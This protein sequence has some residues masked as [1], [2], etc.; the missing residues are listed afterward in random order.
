MTATLLLLLLAQ[1]KPK[2]RTFDES[3]ALAKKEALA[4]NREAALFKVAYAS[5][6]LFDV[7]PQ[8]DRVSDL[9]FQF[10][11]R[12]GCPPGEMKLKSWTLKSG[13]PAPRPGDERTERSGAPPL[14]GKLAGVKT[15][16]DALRAQGM[17][18][19]PKMELAMIHGRALWMTTNGPRAA[20]GQA[21]HFADG[22]TG[23]YVMTCDATLSVL[24][25]VRDQTG[26]LT[27]WKQAVDAVEKDLRAWKVAEAQ[28][29]TAKGSGKGR[30]YLDRDLGMVEWELQVYV[31]KP[32][33]AMVFY[34]ISNGNVAFWGQDSVPADKSHVALLSSWSLTGAGGRMLDHPAVKPFMASQP[35]V[36][37]D[38]LIDAAHMKAGEAVVKLTNLD[39][40]SVLE[41]T[42]DKKGAVKGA[43]AKK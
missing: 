17:K 40:R 5:E 2:A 41:V 19:H 13:D 20:A 18:F 30:K 31:D 24:Q 34:R 37:T 14:P 11:G 4:W 22:V 21:F 33:P 8:S 7:D 1:D 10:A 35:T 15:A 32:S 9:E 38:L 39:N 12:D 27:T 23:E 43:A 16:A 6:L 36:T 29:S 3:L 26:A 25:T 28:L 42:L